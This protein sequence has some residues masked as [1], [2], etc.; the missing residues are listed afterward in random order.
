MSDSL[1]R[2]PF[3]QTPL[4]RRVIAL[5]FH[6]LSREILAAC[7]HL[8]SATWAK[9]LGACCIL[10]GN[11]VL[12]AM[13][14]TY[15]GRLMDGAAPA[16][17]AYDLRFRV[18]GS[19]SGGTQAGADVL[20]SPVGVTNGLFTVSLDFGD[21][22]FTGATRWLEIAARTNGAAGA[23]T[24]LDPRQ[25]ITAVPY[26]LFAMS[27]TGDAGA[28]VTGTVPDA[29]LSLNI[30]RSADVASASNALGAR[31]IATN[32]SAQGQI[33]ALNARL[34]QLTAAVQ[35]LSNRVTAASSNSSIL[36]SRHPNDPALAAM[37]M[38]SFARIDGDGWKNGSSVG[39]PGTRDNPAMVWTG[40][41][42]LMFGGADRGYQY[43]PASDSWSGL[44]PWIASS[45]RRG[46]AAAWTG[47]RAVV[48][49]GEGTGFD[50]FVV[51]QTR[52]DGF[53]YNPS[54]LGF[55]STPLGPAGR[56]RHAFAWTGSRLAI[57]G[58]QSSA[59]L[60]SDGALLDIA[61]GVWTALPS[62]GPPEARR[63]STMTWAGDRL[64]VFGG[65]GV[66]GDLGSGAALPLASGSIPGA[67]R[68][69]STTN[70][71][72]PRSRHAAVWTGNRLVVWGGARNNV[73]LGDGAIYNP[74]TDAWRPMSTNG[75]PV[76]RQGHSAVWTGDE[77]LV[78]GGEDATGPLSSS[79]AY[80]PV[81]DT[82]RPVGLSGALPRVGHSSV[83]TGAELMV[84]GGRTTGGAALGALQRLNPQGTWY[85][86]RKP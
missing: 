19:V 75:A 47:D 66:G 60:L 40:S 53:T 49:G 3:R 65:E 74:A 23:L 33:Q 78:F 10:S 45:S 39:A 29:R 59:G 24:V 31:L 51:G 52:R 67:W 25:P 63:H 32:A 28:L 50:G 35:T 73:A 68:A 4:R 27:G 11:G 61:A 54:T 42:V 58:G 17:G 46:A 83:W 37:G 77:M 5:R 12:A 70:A 9:A 2:S 36:A 13:P 72:G 21:G 26:A 84:F 20:V 1:Q 64:V 22:V 6:A 7:R 8:L 82:W 57:W 85:L 69:L 76:A 79:A 16:N 81:S 38:V 43:D 30:A 55:E 56:Y 86:Y 48:W 18:F 15:Q 80:D 44:P 14:F 34:D 71:P 62:S 41:R